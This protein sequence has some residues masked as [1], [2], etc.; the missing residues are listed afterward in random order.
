M[1]RLEDPLP[2]GPFE[3]VFS[4][5]AVHHLDGEYDVPSSLS[6]QLRW[7]Q[8]AGFRSRVAPAARD[9]AVLA[10][11]TPAADDRIPRR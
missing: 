9:L 7:L 11:V 10:G 1:G 5:L 6:D 4:T 8:A 2:A 3:L